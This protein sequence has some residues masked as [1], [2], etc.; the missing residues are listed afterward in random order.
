MPG[1]PDLLKEAYEAENRLFSTSHCEIGAIL[2]SRWDLD[3]CV[4][5]PILYHHDLESAPAG[6]VALVAIVS[7]ADKFCSLYGYGYEE[8][9]ISRGSKSL[10][11]NPAWIH[12]QE[13]MQHSFTPQDILLRIKHNFKR[14]RIGIDEMSPK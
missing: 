13:S 6:D 7:L 3:E 1:K 9:D 4:I 2:A 12:L 11:E 5:A 10:D 14:I 8:G